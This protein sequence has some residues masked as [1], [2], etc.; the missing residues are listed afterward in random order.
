M[1]AT[2]LS[3]APLLAH[4]VRSGVVESVHHGLLIALDADGAATRQCGDVHAP[5]LPRSALK[6]A[7]ALACLRAGAD[8]T[9]EH[10]ALACASH[11]GEDTHLAGVRAMLEQADLGVDQLDNTPDYPLGEQARLA[12]IAAGRGKESLAQNCSGKHAAMLT[13][14][15]AAGW[16]TAT[17]RE[18]GHPLQVLVEETLAD[19]AGEPVARRTVDGCGAPALGISLMGLARMFAALASAR[20]GTRRAA[21][22]DAMRR[23]PQAVGGTGRVVTDLMRAIPGLI[24]KDGAEGVIAAALPDGRA[25]AVKI[26]DGNARAAGVSLLAALESDGVLELPGVDAS[27]ARTAVRSEILGHG[28]PVG[29]VRAVDNS[30]YG[31]GLRE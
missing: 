2:A 19:L 11:S 20:S 18:V 13:A 25:F 12:W 17:Y 3:D 28:R 6:P 14:C 15:R 22:A 27:A 1:S 23:H 21:V 26:A 10:L 8:L 5:I 4:V 7:Q 31:S 9:G 30:T 29:Q 16:D 24:A